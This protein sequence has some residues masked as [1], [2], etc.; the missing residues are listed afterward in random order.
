[1]STGDFYALCGC[2]PE[3]MRFLLYAAAAACARTTAA[4]LCS[5]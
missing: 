3:L 5:T 4:A 2:E 1:M